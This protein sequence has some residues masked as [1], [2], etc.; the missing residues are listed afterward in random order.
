[1]VEDFD[2]IKMTSENSV[3]RKEFQKLQ[4]KIDNMVRVETFEEYVKEQS[5]IDFVSTAE[6]TVIQD[7]MVQT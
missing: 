4:D 3:G 1:M 2:M 7:S 6:F 5:K